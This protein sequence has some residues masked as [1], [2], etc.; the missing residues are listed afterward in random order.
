MWRYR[1]VVMKSSGGIVAMSGNEVESGIKSWDIDNIDIVYKAN[2][3][4]KS[5]FV[6][7]KEENGGV[8]YVGDGINEGED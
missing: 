8:I 7:K 3:E 2:P 1:R 5:M 4:E 6:S